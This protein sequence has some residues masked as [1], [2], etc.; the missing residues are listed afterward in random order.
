M[1][2]Y[3]SDRL[4]ISGVRLILRSRLAK[5]W[6]AR[7]PKRGTHAEFPGT[8]IAWEEGWYEVV[9]ARALPSGGVEYVLE[10]WRDENAIRVS[11]RYDEESERERLERHRAELRRASQRK[12]ANFF[13]IFL[14]HLPAPVQERLGNELG[15]T[16]T[17]LSLASLILPYLAFAA[18]I[19]LTIDAYT[20]NVP[21]PVP[22]PLALLANAL[23]FESGIR[24]FVI[25][26]QSRPIGSVLGLLAYSIYYGLARDRSRLVPPL[27]GGRGDRL[28]T[29][30]P[31][32]DVALR[33]ELEVRA[34]FLSLLSPAEQRSMERFGY[35]YR[36]HAPSVAWVLL[37]FAAVGAATSYARMRGESSFGALVSMLIAGGVAIEQ[38]YRLVAF[39]RGPA[40]SV[41]AFVV[42][43]FLR[44]LLERR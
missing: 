19:A 7:V 24:L 26:S 29:L 18:S 22:Q 14:G 1:R 8:A 20:R 5:G 13:A 31:P 40:G 3:G 33:D 16:P 35:D 44:K 11:E 39:R 25:L 15:V 27:A 6:T 17:R 12:Q 30:P 37:V 41:F 10:P 43:P 34:P 38:A 4:R 42:R 28:F 23:F 36:R 21:S 2:A 9:E 32:D